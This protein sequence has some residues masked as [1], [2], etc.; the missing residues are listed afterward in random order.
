[1]K[2][3]GVVNLFP[4]F[5]DAFGAFGMVKKAMQQD[6]LMLENFNLRD[7][8]DN[9]KGYIDDRPF[10]GGQGMVF[11]PEPVL[12]AIAAAKAK[13]PQKA[14]VIYVSPAGKPLQQSK[15]Q[16]LASSDNALVFLA[17]RYE[18]V[19][20]RIVDTVVDETISL[21]DYVIS[22]GELAVMVII[23]AI[24]RL[25]PGVLGHPLSAAQDAFSEQNDG[26]LDCPHYTRPENLAGLRV[27]EVLLSGDHEKISTWRRMQ[28]LG[29]TWLKRPDLLKAPLSAQDTAL[30]NEFKREWA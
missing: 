1:M 10:G 24:A 22:G 6:A 13:A 8:S 28:A 29:Q 21:G 12:K 20:Q 4:A 7:Y 2:W 26:L 14:R 5:F 23:D 15:V 3:C 19:D 27:P 25:L 16:E 11:K 30:L 17:G 9:A 18:G